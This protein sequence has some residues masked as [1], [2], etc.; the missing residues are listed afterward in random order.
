M[1]NYEDCEQILP[2]LWVLYLKAMHPDDKI[3]SF[4]QLAT[5]YL[6]GEASSTE[7][8]QLVF[9]LRDI[10]CRDLF[11][12]MSKGWE[13][14][15]EN[16][17]KGFDIDAISHLVEAAVDSER[18]A[19]QEEQSMT[20]MEAGEGRSRWFTR[21]ATV[22]ALAASL[23]L[24][25]IPATL[26]FKS[27]RSVLTSASQPIQWIQRS[28]GPSE[29]LVVTLNDG[30][31]ITLNSG[32]SLSY[33]ETFGPRARLVRLM[34]EAFFDVTHDETHPFVVE[35]PTIRIKVL[36][37]QFNVHAFADG[38]EAKVSL[39]KGRVQVTDL[40]VGARGSEKPFS[41]AP[42]EE[43]GFSPESR[44]SKITPISVQAATGW[45]QDVFVWKREPIFSAMHQLE[46]RFGITVEFADPALVSERVSGSFE[47]ESLEEIFETLQM[48]GVFNFQII[49]DQ[50]KIAR[51]ILSRG[52]RG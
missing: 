36:G 37:T 33:P 16:C 17:Q 19:G 49:R 31:Q 18:S 6:I 27:G 26:Y 7:R 42:G 15:P 25:A 34:G 50:G 40:T 20:S 23:A 29:R 44:V 3:T 46:R 21:P 4:Y 2:D 30:T 52:Q 28:A 51:V 10:E 14:D 12:E 11:A 47:R 32:S 22:A 45:M 1:E 41:L 24:I 8:E 38:S 35:T 43:F 48:T 9:R 5:R 39:I 13:N